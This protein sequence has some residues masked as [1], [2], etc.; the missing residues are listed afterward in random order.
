VR[1]PAEA[2]NAITVG[3]ITADS[4]PFPPNPQRT[5]IGHKR[6]PSPFTCLG[7]VKSV[8]KPELVELAGNLAYDHGVKQWIDN[9]PGLRVATTSP[10]FQQTGKL[11]GY[12]YGTSFAAPKVAL[13]AARVLERYPDATPNLV[14]ALLIQSASPPE[15]VS[16]CGKIERLRLCGFGVPDGDKAL[17]CRPHRATLYYEGSIDADEVKLFAIPVPVEF[18]QVKGRKQLSVTVAYD[19]PVS[20]VNRER[21]AGMYLTWRVARGDVP[22]HAVESAIAEDAEREMESA[23]AEDEPP[24]SKKKTFMTGIL[25]VRP[26]QRSTVQKNVF[27]WSRGEHGDTYHL[28]VTAKATR[29]AYQNASQRF[30]VVVTLECAEGAVDVFTAVRARLGAGRVRV[31]LRS[32]P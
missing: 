31:R 11:L 9:D 20:V 10:R 29:P 16:E 7:G 28:A 18:G 5:S 17:F 6:A 23:S 19:P 13:L 4:D 14:R 32:S 30:S 1:S 26:Q 22:D 8:L 27:T 21:P 25:P 2:L 24:K 15:G 3:G 12:A